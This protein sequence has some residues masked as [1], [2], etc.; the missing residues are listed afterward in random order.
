ITGDVKINGTPATIDLNKKKGAA[1]A[2]LHF[3]AMI[4]EVARR[5]LGLDLGGTVTGAIPVKVVTRTGGDSEDPPMIV[6]ADLTP[7]KIDNLL[8]G[9]VKAAGKPAHATYTLVKTR[10]SLRFD[11]LT[12]T[13]SGTNVKGS[14]ELDAA[15]DIVSANFPVFSMSDGDKGSHKGEQNT[16]RVLRGALPGDIL[17]VANFVKTALAGVAPDKSKEKQAHL[18]L[19]VKIG[20]VVG[21]NGET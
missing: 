17:H 16:D 3:Q 9:W 1:D 18:D 7:V 8:P 14:V 2:E 11:D 4:D 19:D 21:H 13:G 12:I 15:S 6:D 5:R 20:A 10:Q